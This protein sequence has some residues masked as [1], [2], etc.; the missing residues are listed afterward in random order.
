[1]DEGFE[2]DR[3]MCLCKKNP[4]DC[5]C[6]CEECFQNRTQARSAQH[7]PKACLCEINLTFLSEEDTEEDFPPERMCLCPCAR[8]HVSRARLKRMIDALAL[9]RRLLKGGIDPSLLADLLLSK[10]QDVIDGRIEW[11][12]QEAVERA[13]DKAFKGLTLYT[14]VSNYRNDR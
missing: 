11:L 6:G 7:D 12:V 10:I 13:V 8:C 3:S 14:K 9:Q 2:H 5:P 4:K 1:M